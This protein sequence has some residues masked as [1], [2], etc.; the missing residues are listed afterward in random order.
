MWPKK[1]HIAPISDRTKDL[2]DNSCSLNQ[3]SFGGNKIGGRLQGDAKKWS[4]KMWLTLSSNP[5]LRRES[6]SSRAPWTTRPFN[7]AV[8]RFRFSGPPLGAAKSEAWEYIY[9]IYIYICVGIF[10]LHIL[11]NYKGI[12][13]TLLIFHPIHPIPSIRK[14]GPL[15]LAGRSAQDTE[16]TL[17]VLT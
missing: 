8:S 15:G 9:I 12:Q 6:T 5:R 10:I 2:A 13:R 11:T 14:L 17:K 4:T 7:W 1:K 16:G 3:L